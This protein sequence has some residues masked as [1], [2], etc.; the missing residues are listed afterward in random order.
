MNL[1]WVLVFVF[2]GKVYSATKSLEERQL[3]CR[4]LSKNRK[5]QC[6]TEWAELRRKFS[7]YSKLSPSEKDRVDE[8]LICGGQNLIMVMNFRKSI[9]NGAEDIYIPDP[10]CRQFASFLLGGFGTALISLI[11]FTMMG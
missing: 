9:E 11:I 2:V 6:G 8:E 4:A 3:T 10:N 1:W 5:S 7:I